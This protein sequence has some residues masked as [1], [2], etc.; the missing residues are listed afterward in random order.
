MNLHH[1]MHMH[2]HSR[3]L[4]GPCVL[5]ATPGMLQGGV[6]LAVFKAW[7]PVP[8][9]LVVLPSYQAAGSQIGLLVQGKRRQLQ[10]DNW[11]L[12]DVN[13]KVGE[14]DWWGRDCLG[15]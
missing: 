1:T 12:L 8:G 14:S 5:F 4:Q 6:S 9:N 10:I 2:I 7:A 11:T 3:D 13:C 15:I